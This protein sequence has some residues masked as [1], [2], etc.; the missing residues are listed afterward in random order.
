MGKAGADEG[1]AIFASL[2][3]GS[4]NIPDCLDISLADAALSPFKA[5]VEGQIVIF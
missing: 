3:F 1:K 2:H 4:M 5:N